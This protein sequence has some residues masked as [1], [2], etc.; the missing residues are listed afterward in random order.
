MT[1]QLHA[2]VHFGH[3]KTTRDHAAMYE[4]LI[5]ETADQAHEVGMHEVLLHLVSSGF[6]REQYDEVLARM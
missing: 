6:V 3:C 5:C 2:P 4:G 1:V